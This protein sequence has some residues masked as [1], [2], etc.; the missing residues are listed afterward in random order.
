V[1]EAELRSTVQLAPGVLRTDATERGAQ[2][3]DSLSALDFP[4]TG[5]HVL[6]GGAVRRREELGQ[7][8][9]GRSSGRAPEHKRPSGRASKQQRFGEQRSRGLRGMH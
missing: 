2:I 5:V 9:L 4:R 8:G 1:S 6:P 7:S 3:I